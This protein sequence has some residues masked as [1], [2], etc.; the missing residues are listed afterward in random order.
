MH[1]FVAC[2]TF[3][4][5]RESPA[6]TWAEQL[7]EPAVRA[8]ILG[9][10]DEMMAG[11]SAVARI[12]QRQWR[13]ASRRWE[14]LYPVLDG[15][16]YDPPPEHSVKGLAGATPILEFVYAHMM[17]KRCTGTIWEGGHADMSRLYDHLYRNMLDP[18]VL[19]GVSDAGV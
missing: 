13:P 11:D 9:E 16:D 14:R 18:Q 7:A 19:P 4:R 3:K 6:E 1:P 5:V 10:F 12:V 15:F 17:T 2:A 8:A